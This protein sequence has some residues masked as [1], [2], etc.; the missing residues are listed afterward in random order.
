LVRW[1]EHLQAWVKLLVSVHRRFWVG[2]ILFF[3]INPHRDLGEGNNAQQVA[4]KPQRRDTHEHSGG[5]TFA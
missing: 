2:G 1:N 3:L 4:A 5:R